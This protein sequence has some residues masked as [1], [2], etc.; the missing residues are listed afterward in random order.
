[1]K[2]KLD[3]VTNSSSCAFIFI[4]WEI[5]KKE[6]TLKEL[7]KKFGYEWDDECNDYENLHE[8][9]NG[10]VGIKFGDGE[11]GLAEGKIFIGIHN[12]LDDDSWGSENYT[13]ED[14]YKLDDKLKEMFKLE[15]IK[16]ISGM[17]MC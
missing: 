10:D 11:N 6:N 9:Y 15:D 14:V 16:I 2:K 13:I 5:E 3:F 1:M 7:T 8:Y 4:G 12:T 17:R